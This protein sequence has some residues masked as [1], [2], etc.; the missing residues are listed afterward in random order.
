MQVGGESFAVDPG[1]EDII[2]YIGSETKSRGFPKRR[3]GA[4]R[5]IVVVEEATTGDNTVR[6]KGTCPTKEK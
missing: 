3:I 1:L 4:A 5:K 2:R 6:Q